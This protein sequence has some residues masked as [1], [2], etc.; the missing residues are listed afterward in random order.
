MSLDQQSAEA[1]AQ[2]LRGIARAP[3]LRASESAAL[4][5]AAGAIVDL[6]AAAVRRPP[7]LP[8]P[9]GTRALQAILKHIR[10]NP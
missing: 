5:F 8:P 7:L 4:D 10:K 9:A 3:R 2:T 6:A 1:L